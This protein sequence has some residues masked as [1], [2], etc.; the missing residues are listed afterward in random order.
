[1]SITWDWFGNNK[2]GY[3]KKEKMIT[4]YLY[5]GCL[6]L[7]VYI[8]IYI[9]IYTDLYRY[10]YIHIYIFLYIS[11]YLYIYIPRVNIYE[12]DHIGS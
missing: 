7:S 5:S 12:L 1:M 3:R 6:I 9:Y 2:N 10:R 8:Y 11:I 4:D